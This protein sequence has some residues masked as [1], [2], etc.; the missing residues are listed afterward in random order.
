MGVGT[1][2]TI[3]AILPPVVDKNSRGQR[4]RRPLSTPPPHVSAVSLLLPALLLLPFDSDVAVLSASLKGGDVAGMLLLLG[5]VTWQGWMGLGGFVTVVG[6]GDM[7]RLGG[8]V[9]VI[10]GRERASLDS[11]IGVLRAG[12]MALLGDGGVDELTHGLAQIW[13][14]TGV[15][16]GSGGDCA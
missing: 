1:R 2:G 9:G 11:F 14:V 13:A 15:L 7:A 6:G 12:D 3:G 16:N 5:V 8:L 4:I 10:R